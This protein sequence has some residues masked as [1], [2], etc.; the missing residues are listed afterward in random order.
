MPKLQFFDP[1]HVEREVP[2]R[3]WRAIVL[4]TLGA[5]AILTA[6]YEAFWRVKGLTAGDFNNTEALWA[7]ARRRATG[8]ATV[9]IGSSRIF[10]GADLGAWE[11]TTGVR[12][13]QLALE[14]TSPR[15]FLEDLANDPKFHG[16]VIVGVTAPLFFTSAGG[17]RAE[18]ISYY[19]RETLAQRADHFLTKQLERVFAFIDEQSRP[20]RQIAIWSFPLR[21]GMTPNFDPRKLVS[22][23]ADRDAQL[24]RRVETDARYREEAMAMWA[25]GVKR[26]TPPPGPDGKPPQMPDAV[27]TA[28]IAEVKANVD[29][30]RAKGGDVAFVRFPYAGVYTGAED[31]GFPRER[32]WDRLVEET[33]CV[34]V[35]WQDYLGLQG[36]ELPE[37]SH[38]SAAERTRYT[39]ALTPILYREMEAKSDARVRR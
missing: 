1:E 3:P 37:W 10:F 2:E 35:A 6:G 32:F 34:G 20:K 5:T 18:A 38:L 4:A 8:D 24:W 12:P 39:R 29:K 26:N 9:I 25:I 21:D 7:E 31:G 28:V 14:G 15:V 11:E 33:D 16:T 30:I 19:H 27:I 36:Y 23:A 17:L 22:L 13:V